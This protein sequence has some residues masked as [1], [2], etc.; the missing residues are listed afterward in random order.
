V[1]PYADGW[2]DFSRLHARSARPDDAGGRYVKQLDR[3]DVER[4]FD[5]AER[6]GNGWADPATVE[7]FRAFRAGYPKWI[8]KA[9]E[10][11]RAFAPA[12]SAPGPRP[13]GAGSVGTIDLGSA[14][15]GL[16]HKPLRGLEALRPAT[17]D[18]AGANRA[19]GATTANPTPAATPGAE[20]AAATE[21]SAEVG[22]SGGFLET[23]VRARVDEVYGGEVRVAIEVALATRD[24]VVLQGE[25]GVGKSYLALRLLDD[26]ERERSLV[27]PVADAKTCSATSIRSTAASSAR[28]SPSSSS[29][30]RRPGARATGA[31]ASS[32]SRS[33]T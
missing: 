22:D 1:R 5:E 27:V 10:R 21:A 6:A 9:T 30:R 29:A 32:S 24:L 20:S 4:L 26:D 31:R 7:R 11:A 25:P 28:P 8:E 13:S 23:A 15:G 12:P 33:S 14:S 18:A 2:T 16:G 3:R 19:S 17:T